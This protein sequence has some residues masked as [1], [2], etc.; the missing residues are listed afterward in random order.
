M[1]NTKAVTKLCCSVFLE[2]DYYKKWLAQEPQ[3]TNVISSFSRVLFENGDVQEAYELVR[4]EAWGIFCGADNSFLFMHAKQLASEI[5]KRAYS[6]FTVITPTDLVNAGEK[7][8]SWI[9]SVIYPSH[10]KWR[11]P[12]RISFTGLS[13]A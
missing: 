1:N 8:C 5:G 9:F 3:N 10:E 7:I 2:Y 4:K 6:P 13:A 12:H 11:W